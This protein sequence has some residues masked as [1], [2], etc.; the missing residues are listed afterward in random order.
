MD[1]DNII[2]FQ[3]PEI[4]EENISEVDR[5]KAEIEQKNK[6]IE[7]LGERNATIASVNELLRVQFMDIINHI[8]NLQNTLN[9]VMANVKSL[10]SKLPN[11]TPEIRFLSE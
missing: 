2:I 9:S 3:A 6:L 5:L 10:Q 11:T 4:E 7:Y 1:D 8:Q